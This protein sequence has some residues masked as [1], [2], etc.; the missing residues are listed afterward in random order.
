[1]KIYR[2]KKLVCEARVARNMF[3]KAWGW[4]L[5]KP[6]KNEGL[7]FIFMDNYTPLMW[8][9][10]MLTPINMAFLDK[11]IKVVDFQ[12]AVPVTPDPKTWRTY[13][14]KKPCKYVLELHWDNRLK[15]GEK[16]NIIF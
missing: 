3:D 5:H 10:L 9:P 14:P 8:M 4:M 2:G 1:M 11:N 16:L 7:L 13:K 6:G 15:I 12:R